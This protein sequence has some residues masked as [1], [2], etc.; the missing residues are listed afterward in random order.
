MKRI[1]VEAVVHCVQFH[2]LRV[3]YSHID[4]TG[5]NVHQR[6]QGGYLV[7]NW[8]CMSSSDVNGTKEKI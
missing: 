2:V 5:E 6:K 7:S 1:G 3:Q 8:S 4:L